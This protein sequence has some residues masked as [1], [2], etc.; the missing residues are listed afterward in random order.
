MQHQIRFTAQKIARRFIAA[1]AAGLSLAL[2]SSTPLSA[3]LPVP[4]SA[5]SAASPPSPGTPSSLATTPP[6]SSTTPPLGVFLNPHNPI[7]LA[8][9]WIAKNIPCSEK[10][11]LIEFNPWR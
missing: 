3:P 6:T 4:T 7:F 1:R 5:P 9:N 8:K 11:P 2:S 10:H